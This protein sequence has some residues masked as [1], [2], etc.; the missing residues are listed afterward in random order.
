MS[1]VRTRDTDL[2]QLVC[3]ALRKR[4]LRFQR[5]TR[6]LPGKPDV[7]F[8]YA[9]V[10]VFVDGDFWHGYRFPA[11]RSGLSAFWQNKIAMNR[12]RDRRNFARLRRRGWIVVRLWQHEIRRDLEACVERVVGRVRAIPHARTSTLSPAPSSA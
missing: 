1:R 7:V 2:E 5:H 3:R 11:W 8:R 6:D 9:R 10:V 4:G 12:A